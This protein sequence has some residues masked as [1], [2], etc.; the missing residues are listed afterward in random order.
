MKKRE[1]GWGVAGEVPNLKKRH[2]SLVDKF[3]FGNKLVICLPGQFT[4]DKKINLKEISIMKYKYRTENQK[5][6]F[7]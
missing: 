1:A 5:L 3:S 2:E 6:G 7:V 4:T